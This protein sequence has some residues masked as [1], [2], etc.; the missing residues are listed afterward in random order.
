MPD[1][2]SVR[3]GGVSRRRR[4]LLWGTI[5]LIGGLWTANSLA[6]RS[7]GAP[8]LTEDAN[9]Q[10]YLDDLVSDSRVPGI[11]YLV[12]DSGGVLFQYA[13]GWA[14]IYASPSE[15]VVREI[16]EE[17]GY[18]TVAT[19][20]LAIYDKSRHHPESTLILYTYKLFFLCELTGGEPATSIETSDSGFF[21]LDQLPPLSATRNTEKQIRRMF[22]LR[23]E[24][25]VDFD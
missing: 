17:S 19:R 4:R 22:E 5:G 6:L 11:Q 10:A 7:V 12:V 15:N 2:P 1:D 21:G 9:V 20:L 18:E 13:G 8:P 25:I 14:D 16:R 23:E 3:R 24:G